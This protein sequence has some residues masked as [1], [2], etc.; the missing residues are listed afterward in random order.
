MHKK[1]I[2]NRIWFFIGILFMANTLI[3]FSFN[4]IFSI[5]NNMDLE[6]ERDIKESALWGWLNITNTYINYSRY[7]IGEIVPI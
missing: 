3:I 1:I 4:N 6:N 5:E 2:R 7:S